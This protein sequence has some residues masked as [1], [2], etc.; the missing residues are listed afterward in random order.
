LQALGIPS[1]PVQRTDQIL[2]DAHL[3][4]RKWFRPLKH[5]D[6]GTHLYDGVPWHFSDSKLNS[7]LPSPRLG[8]HSRELLHD[9]LGLSQDEI[10]ALFEQGVSGQV[11]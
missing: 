9:L 10:S 11:S 3:K 5:P 2:N 4:N 7:S 8:Q 6:L 1:A